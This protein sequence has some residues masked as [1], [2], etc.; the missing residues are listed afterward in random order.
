[1]RDNVTL[2]YAGKIIF[3]ILYISMLNAYGTLLIK[4]TI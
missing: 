4:H 2:K 1:M 3:A